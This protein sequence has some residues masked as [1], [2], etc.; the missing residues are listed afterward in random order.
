[1]RL[2]N[3][4]STRLFLFSLSLLGL[5]VGLSLWSRPVAA[6]GAD[7]G[8]MDYGF[9]SILPPII[10]LTAAFLMRQVIV[11]LFLGIV[12]GAIAINGFTPQGIWNGLLDTGQVYA[13]SAMADADH[14]A[15][16]LFTLFMQVG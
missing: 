15:V 2:H 7:A 14:V 10:A 12:F 16:I 8:S 9:I 4:S 6:A 13:V 11:A 3:N 5:I 1:M